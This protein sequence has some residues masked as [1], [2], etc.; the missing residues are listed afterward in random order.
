M[1]LSTQSFPHFSPN[2]NPTI[3]SLIQANF[4]T[5]Q[6][7]LYARVVSHQ[8]LPQPQQTEHPLNSKLS[9]QIDDIKVTDLDQFLKIISLI[10]IL[11][12]MH[13]QL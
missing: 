10:E 7:I 11:H 6:G 9:D 8:P 1:H 12:E 4:K 5:K 13:K 2:K 3:S